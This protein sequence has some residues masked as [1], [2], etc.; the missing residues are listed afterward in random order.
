MGE[1][2]IGSGTLLA[3]VGVLA[4]VTFGALSIYLFVKRR[5]P[6]QITFVVED[7]IGLF[8]SI[9]KHFP[10]LAV[11]YKNS[12]VGEGIV[13]LKGA[14]LNT[15]SKDITKE[16]V[17]GRLRL[18]L[19]DKFKWLQAKVV[20]SS[21]DV[22]AQIEQEPRT[23]TFD[24][25]LFR[26]RE[27][28]RF[29]CL[30][31]VPILDDGTASIEAR[32]LKELDVTHRIADTQEV[33]PIHLPR[34]Q[35]AARRSKRAL[36]FLVGMM[37]VG[38]VLAVVI[39]VKGVPAKVHFHIANDSGER[40]EVTAKPQ[41]NGD[42]LIRGVKQKSFKKQIPASDFFLTP[43]LE[44]KVIPDP[45][46]KFLLPATLVFYILVP[47]LVFCLMFRG[48]RKPRQIRGLL[49]L[50]DQDDDSQKEDPTRESSA[51]SG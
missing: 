49:G 37:T 15:G 39:F 18:E 32:L 51:T 45:V 3:I 12:P 35:Y 33:N 43:D 10:E 16:M 6:G 13:L 34:L 26:C 23:L 27:F 17:D 38:V 25:G 40:I 29:E 7:C 47:L 30:A 36:P 46:R 50:L 5:Y 31:E 11:S 42:M 24:T 14:L 21:P 2:D 8:E 4:T 20:F 9:V 28:V 48:Q 41:S 1:V 44:P 22:Q 19:P